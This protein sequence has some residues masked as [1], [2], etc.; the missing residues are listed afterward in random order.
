MHEAHITVSCRSPRPLLSA[1]GLYKVLRL[2]PITHSDP[3]LNNTQSKEDHP[4]WI[5]LT[6]IAVLQ[7]LQEALV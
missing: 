1:A 4:T 6:P 5:N 3:V 2:L 7:R